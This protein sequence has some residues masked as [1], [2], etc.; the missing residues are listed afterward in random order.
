VSAGL[1]IY[2]FDES[3]TQMG[4]AQLI[5]AIPAGEWIQY[6]IEGQTLESA[7]QVEVYVGMGGSPPAG[8]ELYVDDVML[9][10]L[11]G[12]LQVSAGSLLAAAP[13]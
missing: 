13:M 5:E 7:S 6:V 1:T 9:E 8:T 10:Q 11:S 4:Q 2:W 12:Q 3:N